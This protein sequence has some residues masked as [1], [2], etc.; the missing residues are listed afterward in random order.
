MNRQRHR[1]VF[2]R[3][4]GALVAVAECAR[5]QGKAASGARAAGAALAGA[6]LLTA[7]AHA[8]NLPV[9][10]A[11]VGMPSF[12]TSGQAAYQT[13]GNQA[14]V[15]QVGNK[16]IL[17]WQSFNVGAGH[18]VQ[19]RQV[20]DLAGNQLVP[21]AS[22]TTLNRIWDIN[23]S[24]IAGSIGQAPGQKAN[25][26]MVNTNGI[27]FMGGSQVNLNSFTAS[28]LNIADRFIT[29][30]FVP[31]DGV[32]QFQGDTGFI[33]VFEGAQISAGNFGRVMLLAPTVVNRGEVKAPDGQV[34]AAA[35]SKVYLSSAGADSNVRGLLVEIDTPA[36]ATGLD[37]ANTSVRDGVL[38]GRAV[39]LTNAAEDKLG[40]VTNRGTL[41]SDRGNVTMIGLSVNQSGIARASTSVVANGSVYL[42]AADRAIDANGQRLA[43]GA[44]RGGRVVL[45]A[46]SRTEVTIDEQTT[47]DAATGQP[48]PLTSTDNPQLGGSGLDRPSVVAVTGHDVRMEGGAAITARAGRVALTA[49][50]APG[51]A[52]QLVEGGVPASS[53]A[54]LHIADGARIDVSGLDDVQVSVAR[55]SVA[56]ELR[57]DELKDSPINRNGPLR[58]RTAY[59]DVTR[60]LANAE[61]GLPTLIAEDSLAAYAARLERTVSERSTQGGQIELFS[62]GQAVVKSGATLDVSGGKVTY[63]PGVVKTSLLV[64]DGKLTDLADARADVAYS[65][66]ANQYVVDHG[67]WNV[68]ETIELPST[69]QYNAGYVE[70]KAAGGVQVFG[71]KA[72]V[73][74]GQVQGR[75]TAGSLQQ[76]AGTLPRGATLTLGYDDLSAARNAVS[77]LALPTRDFKINQQ[78]VIGQGLARLP[79]G[80]Q[81]GDALPDEQARQLNLDSGLV[82]E[83]KVANL[84]VLS[85]QAVVVR[86]ALRTPQGGSVSLTGASV[87]V[88]AGITARGGSVNLLARNT[89][90][91]MPVSASGAV[92]DPVLRLADGVRIRTEGVFTNARASAPGDRQA[93]V[94]L[95]GGS[96]QLRAES[97]ANGT[98]QASRGQVLL[99]QGVRLDASAGAALAADGSVQQG[100]AGAV[101]I[102]G[103]TV[104]GFTGDTA[105]AYGADRGG[106]LTLGSQRIQVGGAAAATA[107]TLNLD[108]A[109]L[110]RG[111]FGTVQLNGIERVEVAADTTVAPR[112][113]NR[114]LDANAP[115]RASGTA[116]AEVSSVVTRSDE[117]RRAVNLGLSAGQ[118]ELGVGTVVVNAGARIEADPGATVTLSARDAIV[119]DGTVRAQ[120]GRIS[121]TLDRSTGQANTPGNVNP[122]FLGARAVLDASGTFVGY[123]DASGAR[124]ARR[125]DG[126]TV[127]LLARSGYVVTQQ[128]A[129]ID[130][131]GAA[132]QTLDLPNEA[133]GVGRTLGTDGGTVRIRAEEGALLD[134]RL[135][136]QGG[137]ASDRA[138]TFEFTLSQYVQQPAGSPPQ[139]PITLRLDNSVAP[140]TAGLTPASAIP[141]A[142]GTRATLS[143]QALE[144]AGFDRIRLSSRDGIA[145]GDGLAL[146]EGRA[147]PLREL[148]LDAARIRTDNGSA[149]VQAETVRL[150]NF[151]TGRVAAS[152]NAQTAGSLQVQAG[153]IEVAGKL[154]FE[155]MG[156]ARLEA[157]DSLTLSGLSN[158]STRPTG[159]LTSSG[160]LTLSAATVSPSTF[161]DFTVQADG[162]RLRI[163]SPGAAPAQPLS[164]QGRLTLKAADITQAGVLWAPLGSIDLQATGALSFEPGSLTSVAAT[165]GSVLPFGKLVNGRDWVYDVDSTRVPAGQIPV[166]GL[167]GKAVRASGGT[168]KLKQGAR[169][170]L[171]GGGDLQ[172]YEVTVGP[173][174]SSDVLAAAGT[175]AILPGYRGGTAPVDAQEARG[176]DRAVGDAVY[177]SGVP[178]LADG[179]YTLLPGHYALLPG[180]YA[181]RLDS[182]AGAV[183]PGQAYTREDGIRVAAGYFTDTRANATRSSQWQGIQVLSGDQV[184][185]RA[186]FTVARA[187]SFFAGGSRPQDAGLLSVQATQAGAGA[188]AL[189]AQVSGRAGGDGRGLAL[190]LAAPDLAIVGGGATAPA[191]ATVI[192]TAQ[193]AAMGA[194]SILIGGV[195]STASANG[196]AVTT[197]RTQANRVTLANDAGHALSADEV[198]L[199]ARDRIELQDGSVVEGQGAQRAR[200]AV[201]VDGNGA[202]VRAASFDA[203]FER[204]GSPDGSTGVLSAA[205]GATVRASSAI[206]L[207]ATRDNAFGGQLRFE[208]GGQ[209]TKGHFAQG[210]SRFNFGAVP[211]G[212]SGIT[213]SQSALDDFADLASLTLTSYSSFDFHGGVTVGQADAQGRATLGALRLQGGAI[214]GV[215]NDGQTAT[216]R[217]RSLTLA[218]PGGPVAAGATASGSGALRVEAEQLVL[219]TATPQPLP[220]GQTTDNR[221]QVAVAGFAQGVSV[222][223]DEVLARGKAALA[224]D[225]T[226][227]VSTARIAADKGAD[228]ALSSS[229]AMAVTQHAPAAALPGS[230]ALGGRVSLQGPSVRFDTLASLPS[231]QLAITADSGELELGPNARVDV[232][233]R[234]LAFG[235][236][237]AVSPGGAVQLTAKAGNVRV[238]PGARID[239][240][241]PADADG[242]RLQIDA[243][244]GTVSLAAGS[245][246]AGTAGAG[247]GARVAIDAGRV[248]NFSDL[249]AVLEAGGASGARSVRA[250]T[251]D[252]VVAQGDTVRAHEIAL[253]ADAGRVAVNGTLDAS[254]AQA[255]RIGVLAG[256]DLTLGGQALVQ[257]RASAAGENGGQ[258]LLGSREG[259]VALQGGSRVD[260][261][262]G[263]GGRGGTL[264]LRAHRTGTGGAAGT[265]AGAGTGVAVAR[266]DGTV[267]NAAAIH[268]E[269]VKVY[270]GKTTL[271]AT[272]ASTG[273]TLSRSD[274]DSQNTAFAASHGAIKSA[275]GLDSDPRVHVLNGV[276]VRSAGAITLAADWNLDTSKAGGE[277]GVLTLRAQGNVNLNNNLSDGFGVATPCTTPTCAPNAP[278]VAVLR[279]APSWSYRIVAGADASAADPLQLRPAD[280]DVVLASG[281][282]VRTGTGSIDVR[283]ARDIVLQGNGSVI[284]TAGRVADS[285]P[286]YATPNNLLRP[287]FAQDGGDLSLQAQ[288][289]ITAQPSTQLF[290]DWLFRQGAVNLG[291]G[292]FTQTPSWWVRFD[293]F[294][295]G[296][297]ALGG[298]DVSVRA[299]Q[300]VK[301][302][303]V[304]APTQGRTVGAQPGAATTTVTGGGD[305]RIEAGADVLGGAWLAGDGALNVR[306]GRS[307]GASDTAVL[308]GAAPLAP[309]IALG[310]AR[311]RVTAG[312]DLSVQQVLSP[313]AL[314]QSPANLVTGIGLT[315]PARSLF[316]T[317]G[318]DSG[319]QA[320]SIAGDVRL[321]ASRDALESAY[322]ALATLEGRRVADA[323]Y[324]MPPQLSMTAL[325][326]S[327]S[328]GTNSR[329]LLL[330]PSRQGQLALLAADSVKINNLVTLSDQG[331]GVVPTAARPALVNTASG[332][333]SL[334]GVIVNPDAPRAS[335]HASTPVHGADAAPVV[336]VARDGDVAGFYNPALQ[337]L[338]GGIQSAK[339]VLVQA[340]R[341]VQDLSVLA[342]HSDAAQTSRIEAGRDLRFSGS[343]RRE[344]ARI[345]LSGPGALEVTAGR[346]IALGTSAGISS[347]GNLDNP[348]LPEAGA[349]LRLAAGVGPQG[350]Q[351][352]N[353]VTRLLQKLDAGTVDDSSL[354]QARWLTGDATLQAGNA[355][356]AV[357]AVAALDVAQQR[358]K[359]REMLFTALRQTGRDSNDAA[360]G[361]AGNYQRG[362]DTIE[363]L[364]PGIG[365]AG[366]TRYQGKVDLF[367]SRVK[368]ERGGSID[369]LVPG[370]DLVVGLANTPADLVNVGSNVLGM[371]VAGAGDLRGFSRGDML[372]NQSRMLTVGGG[373]VLLWSSEGDID[374]GRG[375]KTASAVPPPLIAIDAQGN[376]TQVL[377]GAVS[378][379]GIGALQSGATP[380]GDV[381]LIAPKGTVNA[382]DAGIRAG[383]LNIAAQV[384][385]GA[386][387]ISVSGTSTGTPVADTSAVTAAAS[388]ATTGGDDAS[389]VVESLN[390]AAAESAKAAQELASALRPSVVRVEVLGYGE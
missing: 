341:D 243:V 317:Y 12:V 353:A 365:Q 140:Q 240:S 176:F 349:D 114:V 290:S 352:E 59:V 370:G 286:G 162:R 331:S 378:G 288:R 79:D 107:G 60:A 390:Q 139:P 367:A 211:A 218:N 24:V 204:T 330:A 321:I 7:T 51:A 121:A 294:Q 263:Q 185:E 357:Q 48:K 178:G 170:D 72:T 49:L 269:A 161:S 97:Q 153:Q 41:A 326:G 213:Y 138:G 209:R 255:G 292:D 144:Q 226:L 368:T 212:T 375:K 373:D 151:D 296:V 120:G 149:R 96:I 361:Y 247:E 124:Q 297:G 380:A 122:I 71:M 83:G 305:V 245:V 289:N 277:P 229:G 280:A 301:D 265:G 32:A 146:G 62:Q 69:W 275:L 363:L 103:H 303:A 385:L 228:L 70:G 250:R 389:R 113:Q 130:V 9:P 66:I 184:R 259:T 311:A 253:A 354:W 87:D 16:A 227:A 252:L 166:A 359:V 327:V 143:A 221:G 323:A 15:N 159:A 360:S 38:D 225:G 308:T 314:V 208:S 298:G 21:G 67:R 165:P 387:N 45:G 156:A 306:A 173:G 369:V 291:T 233:G 272:G 381:D 34:I 203:G 236:A 183:L 332:D 10:S 142:S 132:P 267:A 115:A 61:A 8:Q 248:D 188:I 345:A 126:G 201:Q 92:P 310:D 320:Q 316:T 141:N 260:L 207:D 36:A 14:F 262:G 85:N 175:Y 249:N 246:A 6:L 137:T 78:V 186:E 56:V 164:A 325:Q 179:V 152:G 196:Q 57:G 271:T 169:I 377:Q 376:V 102:A 150:G 192:D 108:P 256:Q 232:A 133:G 234:R 30:S 82:G 116:M 181:V 347:R 307:V 193:I 68:K 223:A 273:S 5:A 52:S 276:E 191:G 285:L 118:S 109:L 257:A 382:G 333:L 283:A 131:S 329:D 312:G 202:F 128:G 17:N 315:Q 284:Y 302:L 50:D 198:M 293:R 372:V 328:V 237:S 220:A 355:R 105:Q 42:V 214:R 348:N 287:V 238:Q 76:R 336:V 299:G 73:M 39:A 383:N 300:T 135:L 274:V 224:V 337:Q 99:G 270:E 210:A 366:Q 63:T 119:I 239:I 200:E 281:K 65:G 64:K 319:L 343:Q 388:G 31:G 282:L 190:D 163:E 358:L 25:V 117:Q 11:G 55:N 379:S 3:H 104:Q 386:D 187:S 112:L 147:R 75:T 80:Y 295:Q 242:G 46:D 86:D 168:V 110:S 241:A 350:L 26:I 27:A 206:V 1:I 125:F 230:Q 177:L 356:A 157:R 268:I 28:S 264:Q 171:S 93:T 145:L 217:A 23:P 58:G 194:D 261:A 231:G 13:L 35:A 74:Q 106:S 29:E 346:D 53:S 235:D 22:F 362:Y 334:P 43:N 189:G 339:P 182:R 127:E 318:D 44:Q 154:Q 77:T 40:A 2:S 322:P 134:G 371:V 111:G 338:Y 98:V 219:G 216:L 174:G 94:A 278:S 19:F 172:A 160:D 101:T 254:G 351:L 167:E 205:S 244:A 90:G 88:Q 158:G 197:V 324:V 4:L 251:G 340:G 335:D 374:A 180:A 136:A 342:Q 91:T 304:S 47:I 313:Q 279:A 344:R 100:A 222:R 37:V 123:T 148:T 95:D 84:R 20:Q 364:F 18:S 81:V 195:R 54:S 215:N 258:V 33:K 129:T 155:G 384:V 89:A 309:V 199:S 266:V